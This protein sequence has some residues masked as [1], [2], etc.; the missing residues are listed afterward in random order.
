M[1]NDDSEMPDVIRNRDKY[2]VGWTGGLPETP[3]GFGSKLSSTVQQR[4]AIELILEQLPIETI[5]DVGAGD[6]NWIKHTDLKGAKYQAFDLFPRHPDVK[7]IDLV[8]EVPPRADL[9]M[10]IWVLN[11]LTHDEARKALDNLENSRSTWLLMTWEQ[12]LPDF[13]DLPYTNQ[14]V[15]RERSDPAKGHCY[16]RLVPL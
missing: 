12:R 10:C 7:E 15:I 13:L 14:W 8:K 1:S 4:A 3:C 11:H 6:L 9:L 16:L 2:K 5:V